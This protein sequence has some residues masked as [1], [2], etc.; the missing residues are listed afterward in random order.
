MSIM[1][2]NEEKIIIDRTLEQIL[3]SNKEINPKMSEKFLILLKNIGVDFI[4]IDKSVIDSIKKF[5]EDLKYIYIVRNTLDIKSINKYSMKFEYIVLNYDNTEDKELID[6]LRDKNIILEIDIRILD[7]LFIEKNL[8][9][10]QKM[11]IK[12]IRIKNVVKYNLCVWKRLICDIKKKFNVKVDFY[13]SNK[14]YMATAVGIEACIDGADSITAVFNGQN[15]GRASLE[16]VLLGLHVMKKATVFGNFKLIGETAKVYSSL[17]N[18]KIYSMKAVIGEDIFKYESGIHVDG[19]NKNPHTYEPYNPYDIG[20]K[21][22]MYIGKHSGKKAIMI[23][24]NQLNIDYSDIDINEFLKKVTGLSIKLK[25]NIYDN[26][27]VEIFNKF[28]N[29][30]LK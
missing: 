16:E 17:V 29:T 21:R 19:I 14:F 6:S 22:T 3:K 27:L 9:K 15:F 10:F 28:K 25:R 8:I 1:L 5:P 12:I 4:E 7:K 26:E 23:R 30:C 11:N 20:K 13:P 24:L 18:D 2:K